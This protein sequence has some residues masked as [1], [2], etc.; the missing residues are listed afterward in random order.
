MLHP[1]TRVSHAGRCGLVTRAGYNEL[2]CGLVGR[3]S[4]RE[5]TVLAQALCYS[6]W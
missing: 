6:L 1:S 5:R 4:Y 3:G 2:M